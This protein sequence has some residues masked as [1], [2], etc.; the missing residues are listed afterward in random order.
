MLEKKPDNKSDNKKPDDE[1]KYDNG[2]NNDGNINKNDDNILIISLKEKNTRKIANIINNKTSIKILNY[3]AKKDYS[4]ETEIARELGLP[5]STIHYNLQLML[6]T[7]LVKAE[8]YHYSK[9]GKEILHYK[10]AKKYIIITP[11][12][13]NNESIRKIKNYLPAIIIISIIGM[14]YLIKKLLI[15]PIIKQTGLMSTQSKALSQPIELGTKEIIRQETIKNTIPW[16]HTLIIFLLGIIT[17]LVIAL[18]IRAIINKTNH[19]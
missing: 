14:T 9:K 13:T 17:G 2:K 3:L 7:G 18:I 8:E 4:T 5:I 12:T 15:N 6:T 1:K 16:Q 10:T 19:K 11:E